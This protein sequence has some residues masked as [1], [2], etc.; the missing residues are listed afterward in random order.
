[1]KPR[2]EHWKVAPG[3]FKAMFSL[4]A[5]L[6]D[7]GL[8]KGLLHMVKLRAS[9]INEAWSHQRL[10]VLLGQRGM[11]QALGASLWRVRSPGSC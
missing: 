6:R 7:C 5:Y 4:E 9:Q 10:E 11:A 3:A 1:M 2:M 8:D